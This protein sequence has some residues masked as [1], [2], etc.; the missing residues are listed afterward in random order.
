[1][2]LIHDQ[3]VIN[4]KN[5]RKVSRIKFSICFEKRNAHFLSEISYCYALFPIFERMKNMH[6]K[7]LSKCL[8][9]ILFPIT[10][11]CQGNF[12]QS[13]PKLVVGI[14]VDQMRWD[15]L[16]R[17]YDRYSDGGFK[18]LLN[19]GFSCENT[20]IHYLPSYTAV[21]HSCI[22]TGSVP[23]ING[24]AGNDWIDKKT[25][26]DI[27]CTD[28]STVSTVGAEG[29]AGK[30]SP[31]H[32]LTT[33][34]TDELRLATNFASKVVGV[35][36]K[37]RASI[38]PAGH[39]ANA[40][41]W[42]DDASGNFISST[43]YMNQLPDWVTRFNKKQ[44]VKKFMQKKWET[45][46]PIQTY[47]QSDADDQ[48][49]EGKF[50]GESAP[51]FPH[52]LEDAYAKNKGTFR[53]TPF[54]NTLI[55]DFAKEALKNYQLGEGKN[56]DFLTINCASTDYVGHKFGPNSIEVEDTYLRLDKDLEAFFKYLDDNIGK[57]QYLIFL[58]ADHGAAQAIGFNEAHHIPSDLWN[59]GRISDQLNDYL[60]NIFGIEKLSYGIMNYQVFLN[61]PKMDQEKLDREKVK[62]AA[63]DF[64]QKIP[65]V[66][67]TIDVADIG[68][69]P[70][71]EPIKSMVINGYNQSRSGDIQI[72][73]QPGWFEGSNITGTTHG[74]W[75]PYDTHIP[76][77][78][79]GW[80]IAP[81]HTNRLIHM[82]DIAPTV[83]ALLHIQMPNGNVGTA[84]TEVIP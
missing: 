47:Q 39:T 49:Y 14:V 74:T 54:G 25:G 32:L 27:Y 38:L 13:R 44:Y 56:T 7:F 18:R 4:L 17:Y 84:I 29:N 2:L 62:S 12:S 82:E 6:M 59:D 19:E 50:S 46:Y 9:A 78:W 35:S 22:F 67:Y 33:T 24:I 43:Y 79:Y 37:D 8:L 73:L 66:M 11:I 3:Q 16:Y 15:Y 80:K 72:I 45:L 51:V 26:R 31:A 76:L 60:K 28:D 69:T 65:G 70:L 48:S 42:M 68:N 52:R 36:L 64:L 20:M 40:V 61:D 77:L 75:N 81:G 30:M 63:I 23:A 53:S 41:F 5:C 55:L 58:T 57:G 10:A 1:L 21:G 83:A 71:P 34:V